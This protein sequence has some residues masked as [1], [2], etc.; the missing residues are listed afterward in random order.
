WPR[1]RPAARDPARAR[2]G[3]DAP[4]P[5]EDRD[6]PR[7]AAEAWPPGRGGVARHVPP[8]SRR[9]RSPRPTAGLEP[10][11]ADRGV[12]APHALRREGVPVRAGGLATASGES[13]RVLGGRLRRDDVAPSVSEGDPPGSGEDICTR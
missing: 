2:D 11:S 7:G 3:R 8:P 12:R 1:P 13:P 4:R 5:G 6:P 10:P 9:G